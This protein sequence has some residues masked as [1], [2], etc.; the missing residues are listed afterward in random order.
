[1]VITKLHLSTSPLKTDGIIAD[2][3]SYADPQCLGIIL[4]TLASSAKVW[5]L[6]DKEKLKGQC[7][8]RTSKVS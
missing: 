2:V 3:P 1:M 7:L 5:V 8:Q 6:S 4:A